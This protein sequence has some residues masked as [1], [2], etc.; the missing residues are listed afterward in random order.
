MATIHF[1]HGFIGFGKTT[2]A[3]KLESKF[4][5]IR[6]NNDE[7]MVKLYG[8]NPPAE[9]FKE[10]YNRIND[11]QWELTEKLIKAGIDVIRDNGSWEKEKR[12]I[13]VTRAKKITDSIV[14]HSVKC[15][16]K[17]AK[18]RTLKRNADSEQLYINE[19]T[20]DKLLQKF[21]PISE[22]EGYKIVYYDGE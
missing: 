14:F 20:F 4:S 21:E 22:S 11:L 5:A 18:E 9:H 7:W 8:Q 16:L 1:M 2:V 19:N 17:T 12:A 13:D 15:S 3:Q 10:Y 6:L